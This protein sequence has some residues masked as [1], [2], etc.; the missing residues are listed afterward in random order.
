MDRWVYSYIEKMWWTK[1]NVSSTEYRELLNLIESM[2]GRIDIMDTNVKSVRGLVNRKI[3]PAAREEESAEV[4]LTAEDK[5]FIQGLNPQER[6]MIMEKVKNAG[7]L[8]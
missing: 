6:D 8:Q 2:Q 7:N 5:E 3:T 4:G 1:R